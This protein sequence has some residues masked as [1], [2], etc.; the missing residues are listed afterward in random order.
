LWKKQKL[1]KKKGARVCKETYL[2]QATNPGERAIG[3]AEREDGLLGLVTSHSHNVL[4]FVLSLK[5]TVEKWV[6]EQFY[7]FFFFFFLWSLFQSFLSS[8]PHC[9]LF[10]FLIL[11]LIKGDMFNSASIP[12]ARNL[13]DEAIR[14]IWA[15]SVDKDLRWWV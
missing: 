12:L 9:Y 8:Q 13:C 3:C 1:K 5:E 6:E 11:T 14:I 2:L 4:I 10:Y 7:R 15:F